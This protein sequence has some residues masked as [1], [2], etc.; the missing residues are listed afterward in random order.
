M[1]T[2]ERV[3]KNTGILYIRM[4]L[5]IFLNFYSTRLILEVLGVE[6]FG[7]FNVVAG[8]IAVLSF[9]N[10][11]MASAT[12]RFI[13]IAEGAG[14]V[15]EVHKIF[16]SSFVLH[17]LIA[18]L[19]A[20]VLELV[21]YVLFESVLKI[22]ENKIGA[23]QLVYQ[24][25]IVSTILTIVAVPYD[26]VINAHENMLMVAILG[27]LESIF[28]F[29]IAIALYQS[30]YQENLIMYG[31]FTSVS[32]TVILGI[33]VIYCRINYQE[34]KLSLT[35][36]VDRSK[37]KEMFTFASWNFLSSGSSILTMQGMAILLNRYFGVGVNAAHAISNQIAGQLMVFSNT[38]LK[39]LNPVIVKSRGAGNKEFSVRSAYTGAKLSYCLFSIF[40]IPVIIEMPYLL[41]IWLKDVPEMAV[42]F[43]RLTLVRLAVTQLSITLSTAIEADGK[44]KGM[45]LWTSFAYFAVLPVSLVLFHLGLQS[46]WI[47]VSLIFMSVGLLII[48]LYY[49]SIFNVF[50]AKKYV[51]EVVLPCLSASAATY[52]VSICLKYMIPESFISSIIIFVVS[53]ITFCVI[54]FTFLLDKSERGIINSMGSK[55]FKAINPRLAITKK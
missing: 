24:F 49:G 30:A 6:E 5:T 52:L 2:A 23:A 16:N 38:L 50:D 26:A 25:M 9:L 45:S 15:S 13:S 3:I 8:T 20:V 37:L 12:Q 34:C 42:L 19:V 17:L 36:K 18:V 35:N 32:V 55:L 33:K 7:I 21:G 1:G 29:I 27:F 47:Y 44:I 28:R 4:A 51:T 22:P 10:N 31:L 54:S 39:A 40:S 14:K 46:F 43:A 48:R 11:A 41:G 53:G